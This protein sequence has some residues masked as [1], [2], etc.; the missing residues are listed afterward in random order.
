MMNTN[1]GILGYCSNIHP[2]EIW[3]EH[4]AELKDKLPK[5]KAAVCPDKPFGFGLRIANEASK[6]LEAPEK[7]LEFKDWLKQ[8]NLFVFTLNG[9]PFGGFHGVR[10]KDSVHA[11]DWRSQER[12]EYTKRLVNHLA[13]LLPDEMAEGGISTSP[14][15]YKPWF[16]NS[17]NLLSAT[18]ESTNHLM[19]VILYAEKVY[20]KTGKKIHLS[21]EPEPDGILGDHQDFIDWYENILLKHGKNYLASKGYPKDLI[22]EFIHDYI[23][24]CFD[25]CHYGVNFDS[26]NRSLEDLASRKIKI[27]K[28][29]ISS[30]VKMSFTQNKAEEIKELEKYQDEIYL[31]QVK[32]KTKSQ[33]Y[34]TFLDLPEALNSFSED[35]EE[36]RIHFHVPIFIERYDLISS[37]QAEIRETIEYIKRKNEKAIME[38]E[39]Y[40]WG[41]LPREM[42]TNI[43]HS[44]SREINWVLDQ[45]KK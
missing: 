26:I 7:L 16:T 42:Q 27:G 32:A 41:V 3:E 18:I 9:F 35:F 39:T 19:E 1:W 28:Y 23:R 36:W 4:F 37:T 20:Q 34:K 22:E 30:A 6:T 33:G 43:V 11:P 40:T 14:L 17:I 31:H 45:L 24:I 13:N 44:I 25:V 29:Q 5:V 2:G 12:M 38:I 10:V 21:I 8:E 15:S